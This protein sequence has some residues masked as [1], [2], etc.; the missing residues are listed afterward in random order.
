MMKF[1]GVLGLLCSL[2]SS[3]FALDR[4]AFTFTKYD[5]TVRIEPEQQRLGVRGKI[6]LRNDSDSAQKNLALQVSSSLDWRS[7]QASG[8][9]VQFVTQ[10]YTSD[11]DHTGALSEAI[12]T[13]SAEIPSKG[14]VELEIGYEGPLTLDATR[15][16]R[17]GVPQQTASH[18][19][20]DQ[21]SRS[22]TGIRGIGY[23]VWYPVATDAA[24]LSDANSVF[25]TVQRWQLRT[26]ASVMKLSLCFFASGAFKMPLGVMNEKPLPGIPAGSFSGTGGGE[27]T[28]CSDHVFEP[29][30][31]TVPTIAAAAYQVLNQ[32]DGN[33]YFLPEHQTGAG[34]FAAATEKA[35]PFI[36]GWFGAP[37]YRRIADLGDPQAAPFESGSLFLTPL[38]FTV[39]SAESTAVHQLAHAAFFS[40][41]PWI[42]EGLAHFAQAISVEHQNGRQA[43]IDFMGAYQPQVRETE[44]TIAAEHSPR[45]ATDQSLV[46]TSDEE[47]YRS[48]AMYVWW[49]LRDLVG[50]E[51]LK[52]AMAAYRPGED[53]DPSYIQRLIGTQSKKDLE[54]FFD[55]WVYRDRAL[56]DFHIVSVYPRQTMKNTYL[57]TVT[58]ENLGEAAAEVP[59]SVQFKGGQ[60]SGRVMVRGKSQESTRIETAGPPDQVVVND[61][62]VPEGDLTNNI[63]TITTPAK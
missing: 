26:A 10:S 61:G 18:T 6:T 15:L 13:L 1:Y 27:A 23:V 19:D 39:A 49:M 24:N 4:N 32:K 44:R 11:I 28:Q 60:S 38:N 41:R 53:K 52:K 29:M 17:I 50:E 16:T 46:N 62:S 63:F 47:F 21:I 14:A 33:I 20:W 3:G 34:N 54:W 40:P 31:G 12:V 2:M 57:V 45:S 42:Y 56:P 35:A 5:L 51:S 48:K 25:D 22:F 8:Q 30:G 7:I 43:A 55:N 36:A 58:V 37:G 9:P 59:I